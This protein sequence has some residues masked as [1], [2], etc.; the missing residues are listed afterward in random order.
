[1][2]SRRAG[3]VLLEPTRPHC[4]GQ[5]GEEEEEGGE[6]RQGTQG[7]GGGVR[8]RSFGGVGCISD[9][10]NGEGRE[11]LR[12]KSG[13]GGQGGHGAEGEPQEGVSEV[14]HSRGLSCFTRGFVRQCERGDLSTEA[15]EYFLPLMSFPSC[16]ASLPHF[17]FP[18]LRTLPVAIHAA[19]GGPSFN[20]ACH[21]LSLPSPVLGEVLASNTL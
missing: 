13:E 17:Y 12:E 14:R 5:E 7:T 16:R 10:E 8:S 20:S 15:S 3:F 4:L 1:M 19:F 11:E 21:S 9:A 2:R 18:A 6:P